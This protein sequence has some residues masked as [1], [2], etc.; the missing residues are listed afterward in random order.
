MQTA[1]LFTR[2]SRMATAGLDLLYPPKCT[3]CNRE[4][5]FICDPCL[6]AQPRLRPP[7][8]V[9][10]SQPLSRGNVC[11]ECRNEPMAIDAIR[12]PFLM[13]GAVRHA[14]HRL[15]YSNLRA[16]APFLGL[17]LADHM[18]SEGLRGDALVPVPLHPRRERQRGYNQAKLLAREAG[19]LLG[20]AVEPRCLSR[21][22]NAPPQARSQSSIDRKTNVRDSF[23]CPVPSQ[24]DGRGLDTRGRRLHNRRN[25]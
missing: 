24:A 6:S 3:G 22:G 14:V 2:I 7:Y 18:S 20:V 1:T 11:V 13:E 15:K 17:L 12:A 25:A 10:C 21:V 8:C 9:A 5:Q 16:I 23:V 19:K 4:G